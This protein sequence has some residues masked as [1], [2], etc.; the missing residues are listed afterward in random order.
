[1]PVEGFRKMNIQREKDGE[2]LFANPRNATAGSLKQLDPRIVAKRPLGAVFYAVG[3]HEGIAF[4]TQADTLRALKEL[5]FPT[6]QMWWLCKDIDEVMARAEELQKK[7][8]ELPYEI[9]GAVVKV[10]NLDQ[11]KRLGT[12]AKAPR[13]RDRL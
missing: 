6:P 10:N 9:D 4:K 2:E 7:E 8:S 11:W 12:T 5:G 13:L 1:M 3:S